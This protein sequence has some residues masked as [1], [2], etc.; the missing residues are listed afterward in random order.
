MPPIE[1]AVIA[2]AGIGSRLGHGI[3][4]CLVEVGGRPLIEHQLELLSAIADIRVV[5]GYMEQTVIDAVRRVNGSVIFVRNPNYR[6]TTTQESYAL[7]AEGLTGACL[8][9]D[10]DIVFDAQSLGAFL[11]SAAHNALTIGVTAAKTDNAVFAETRRTANSFE[12][13]SF[14]SQQ[15]EFEWAN[16]VSAPAGTF[17]RGGGPVFETLQ[18]LLPAAAAEIISYEIDTEQ[19]LERAREFVR[20]K[21]SDATSTP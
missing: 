7:G 17:V 11:A 16:I 1:H 15:S 18:K 3:P 2:A 12:I 8:F 14:S 20:Y 6:D 19:D 5:V 21:L 10:A 9:L 4:K 13:V